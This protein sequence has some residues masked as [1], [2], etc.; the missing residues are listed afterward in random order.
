MKIKKPKLL[1]L[2]ILLTQGLGVIPSF[3]TANSIDTWY[4]TINKPVFTPP[5]WVFGPVWTILFLLMGIALYMIWARK[6]MDLVSLFIIHMGFNMLWSV[7]FFGLQMPGLALIEINLLVLF[8][9]YLTYRFWKVEKWAGILLVPY[10]L[11][12]IFAT[13]LNYAI[14]RL[15]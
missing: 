12:G 5:S 7:L 6:E 14:W 9:A 8:V 10:L 4:Q 11:W 1:I 13:F 3:A 15:N 2:S